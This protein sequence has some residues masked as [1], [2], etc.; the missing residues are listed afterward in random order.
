VPADQADTRLSLTIAHA[1][2][3]APLARTELD[4]PGRCRQLLE[5]DLARTAPRVESLRE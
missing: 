4:S 5:L 1:Y 2:R 3:T